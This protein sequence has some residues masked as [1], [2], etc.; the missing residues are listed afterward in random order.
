MNFVSITGPA[1]WASYLVNGDASGIDTTER[2]HADAWLLLNEVANVVDCEDE[3]RFTWY[4][5]VHDTLATC[6][7]GD[8]IDYTC[9]V[10]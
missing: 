7:G 9:E 10:R 4:Y 1:C 2:E 8:V 5:G 3:P 6:S